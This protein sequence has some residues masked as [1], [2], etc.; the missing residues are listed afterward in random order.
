MIT[1]L[2]DPSFR[3]AAFPDVPD[4]SSNDRRVKKFRQR[5]FE[6][7]RKK[8]RSQGARLPTTEAYGKYAAGRREEGQRRIGTF[9]EA[10][11]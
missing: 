5:L 6:R 2:P 11:R 7:Q 9:S 8:L 4:S 3:R 1:L 10:V